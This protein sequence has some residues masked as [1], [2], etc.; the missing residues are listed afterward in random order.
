MKYLKIHLLQ[1]NNQLVYPVSYQLELGNFAK[2]HL[3]YDDDIGESYLLLAVEDADY[4]DT[5]VRERV[6]VISEVDA[7][8]I[9]E[10]KEQRTETIIDEAK[11]RR[12]EIKSRLGMTLSKDESDALDPTKPGAIFSTNKIFA[13][14]VVDLKAKE[15]NK[16]AK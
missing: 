14:R 11:L 10:S 1:Q 6:E 7:N 16:I 12:L 2:D 3:Y 9:S 13:D 15:A 8:A 5:M 4:K